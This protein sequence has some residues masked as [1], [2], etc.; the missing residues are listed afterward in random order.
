MPTGE[1]LTVS[2]GIVWQAAHIPVPGHYCVVGLIGNA[3]DPAPG[4]TDF[5]DWDNFRR[6]IRD[7][8]NV[9]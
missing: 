3:A 2:D 1:H 5:L 9:T 7:N 6:F 8:N 4:P